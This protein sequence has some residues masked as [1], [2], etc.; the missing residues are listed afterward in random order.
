[1]L[2]ATCKMEP[3]MNEPMFSLQQSGQG[4]ARRGFA[5]PGGQ[6]PDDP[7]TET[8]RRARQIGLPLARP[9]PA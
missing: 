3:T 1:M 6:S 8:P 2:H 9:S 5:V 4:A 7:A